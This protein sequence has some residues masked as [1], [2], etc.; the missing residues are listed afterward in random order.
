MGGGTFH[1]YCTLCTFEQ[2]SAATITMVVREDGSEA[3]CPE[4]NAR[5]TAE[6]ATGTP[7]DTLVA[8]GRVRE[9]HALVCLS[10]GGNEFYAWS[11]LRKE[12]AHLVCRACGKPGL[13]P[14]SG[15]TGCLTAPLASFRRPACPICKDGRL[16]SEGIGGS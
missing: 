13:Y 2:Q 6:E 7:W 11:G 16:V 8:A 4:P 1:L 15:E 9:R 10:C 12:A 3:L 14:I 5:R